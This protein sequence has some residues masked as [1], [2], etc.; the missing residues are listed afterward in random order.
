MPNESTDLHVFGPFPIPFKKNG[1]GVSKRITKENAASFL[2][3]DDGKSI[4]P[5][6]GVYI[7]ALRAGKGFTPWY[8]GKATKSFK[9]EA[10]HQ[11]KLD[12]YND[13]IYHGQKGTPVMFFV[14][15]PGDLKKISRPIIDE[16]E[17]FLIQS[18]YYKND[19][20]KNVQHAK[21]HT[22]GI[23]GVIRGGKGRAPANAG[24]FRLMMR[25]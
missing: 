12:C 1:N 17:K 9:Q 14:S 2:A 19:G 23:K 16:L 21:K 5:K 13:V 22:W 4:G 11:M 7:F 24:Q 3:S 25:L 18:A 8:V 10:L 20:L 15:K 6:Q